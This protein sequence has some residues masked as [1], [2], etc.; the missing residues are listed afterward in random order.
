MELGQGMSMSVLLL[1]TIGPM[2]PWAEMLK[3]ALPVMDIHTWPY[4]GDPAD[5]NYVV[6]AKV[7]P[8]ALGR[9][10][11]LRLIICLRAGR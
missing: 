7:P 3:T 2:A 6:V 10:P 9:F 11:N 8:G 4:D 1:S 5:I